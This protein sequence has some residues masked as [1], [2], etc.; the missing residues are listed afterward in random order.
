MQ[1]IRRINGCDGSD[2]WTGLAAG[3]ICGLVASWAMNRFQEVW[4][5]LAKR[6]EPWSENQFQ[7]VWAEFGEGIKESFGTQ[8][9]KA[10]P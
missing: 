5:K 6:I 8:G 1:D 9:S 7:N 4:S 3:L 10:G 2:V